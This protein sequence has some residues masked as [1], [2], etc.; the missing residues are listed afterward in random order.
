MARDSHHP[1]PALDLQ[2]QELVL[3][4]DLSMMSR[5]AVNSS[6]TPRKNFHPTSRVRTSFLS[7]RTSRAVTKST[8]G[9]QAFSSA[10]VS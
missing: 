7:F 5:P 6:K 2:R 10:P 3:K 1:A 9:G 8:A 4:A